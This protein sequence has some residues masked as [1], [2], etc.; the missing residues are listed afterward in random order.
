[1]LGG[2]H[3]VV[4]VEQP[5]GLLGDPRVVGGVDDGRAVALG[6]LAEPVEDLAGTFVVEVSGRLVR[7]QQRAAGGHRGQQGQPLLL[8][9]GELVDPVPVLRR[10]AQRPEHVVGVPAAGHPDVARRGQVLDQ[11]AARPLVD[12]RH[13]AVPPPAQPA[14]A[15]VGEHRGAVGDGSCRGPV[16]P[17]EQPDQGALPAAGRP[18][19]GGQAARL[20]HQVAPA[21][22]LDLLGQAAVDPHQLVGHHAGVRPVTHRAAAR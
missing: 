4:E 5:V 20:Q 14:G 16:Q 21:H 3:A 22:R 13:G 8:A 11:V 12:E 19:H 6:D 10:E 2:E 9:T 17:G 18:E 1:V 15:Q 7:D